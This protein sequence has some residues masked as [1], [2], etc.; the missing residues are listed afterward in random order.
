VRAVL[1]L[2]HKCTSS[3][4]FACWPT[5]T[6]LGVLRQIGSI[7]RQ[8]AGAGGYLPSTAES[9]RWAFSVEPLDGWGDSG[10]QQ[11]ATAGWLAALPVFEPHWQV[12]QQL[13]S[14]WTDDAEKVCVCL[15]V[16]A[17][18]A[19]LFNLACALCTL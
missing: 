2:L 9:C 17:D 3:G 15:S 1:Q 8:E 16:W 7:S 11:K 6:W 4:C 10:G 14:V 12:R 18:G 13:L 5:P 19:E